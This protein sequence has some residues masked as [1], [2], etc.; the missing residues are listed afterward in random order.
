MAR[1]QMSAVDADARI[2]SQLSNEERLAHADIV[3]D[4]NCALADLRGRV[5]S[6]WDALAVRSA[7]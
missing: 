1:N 2:R 7:Q 5:Q 4:T 3:I 6:A